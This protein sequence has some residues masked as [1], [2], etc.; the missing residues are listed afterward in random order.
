MMVRDK[1]KIVILTNSVLHKH[2]N[3]DQSNNNNQNIADRKTNYSDD[4]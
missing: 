2:S 4:I 3:L 1:L